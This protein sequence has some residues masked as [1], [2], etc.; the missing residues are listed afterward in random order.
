MRIPIVI[1]LWAGDNSHDFEY[2]RQSIPSLLRSDLPKGAEICLFDDC[3]PN[4][5][6]RPFLDD[7][8]HTDKR[9]RLFRFDKNKGPNKGQEDAYRI[10]RSEYPDSPLYLNLDDDVVYS[11]T[12]FNEILLCRQKMLST[13]IDGIF[14]AMNMPLRPHFRRMANGN[15]VYLLKR[16]QPALNWVIPNGILKAV[17]SFKDEGI[18]Y[19]SVYS[20]RMRLFGYPIIC[21][22][23]SFAQNI[24]L[25]GAYATD[26]ATTAGDFIGEGEGASRREYLFNSMYFKAWR[27]YKFLKTQFRYGTQIHGPIRWGS[28]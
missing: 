6:L 25:Q 28:E 9:I 7:L 5:A 27:L 18:A 24:G 22:K 17:G 10:I 19:D 13:G 2:I 8:S 4:P 12:W 15:R 1:K 3:S 14:S 23:P 16:R 21:I 11:K 26:A 20:Y